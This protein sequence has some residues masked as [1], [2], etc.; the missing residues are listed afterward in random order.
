MD[1]LLV[2]FIGWISV[3]LLVVG[4]ALGKN[5]KPSKPLTFWDVVFYLV[6]FQFIF[7]K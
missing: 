5:R 2:Y 6:L 7:R 3:G 4:C 1:L